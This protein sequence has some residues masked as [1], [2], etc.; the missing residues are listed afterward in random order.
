MFNE[1]LG[2]SLRVIGYAVIFAGSAFVLRL[3]VRIPD[4][5]FRKLLHCIALGALIPFVFAFEH[6]YCSALS[7]IIIAVLLFPAL[8]LAGKIPG[9]SSFISERKSG[10]MKYSMLLFFSS[11]VIAITVCWGLL[12]DRYL[13]LA[14]VYAWGF[15]DAAA[16]L[17]GKRFGKV[18]IPFPHADHNKSIAG[19]N[20]MFF[21]SFVVTAVILYLRGGMSP[22]GYV[23]VPFFTAI[24]AALS[25]L[26]TPDG[27]DTI[28]CPMAAMLVLILLT[29]LF[30]V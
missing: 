11:Y 19:T 13:V 23:A 27:F 17:I 9:F 8:I 30:G 15:G 1:I 6:W 20:A 26:Y 22:V 29:K 10:E 7:I 5:L 25:E 24:A 28:T 3:L 16:A 21:T 4:E 2:G 14:S 12:K 18:K